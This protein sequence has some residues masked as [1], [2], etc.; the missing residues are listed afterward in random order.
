MFFV[1]L[2]TLFTLAACAGEQG[3]KGDQ[4][5]QGPIGV[6]GPTGPQGPEGPTGPQGPAGRDGVD[7]VSIASA[8]MNHLGELIIQLSNGNRINVGKVVGKDGVDGQDGQD[9]QD[10]AGVE[11][12]VSSSGMLQWKLV[13]SEAWIDLLVVATPSQQ[14][15]VVELE[16]VFT[17]LGKL[18]GTSDDKY[19][20]LSTDGVWELDQNVFLYNGAGVYMKNTANLIHE[21]SY[22]TANLE[23][24]KV[25]DVV[26]TNGK[27]TSLRLVN[28]ENLATMKS[29]AANI[30]FADPDISV[31]FG[32]TVDEL[33]A[34]LN[35]P[36]NSTH[37]V[38]S[39]T[40]VFTG[41]FNRA[42]SNYSLVV[43]SELGVPKTYTI[44]YL[45]TPDYKVLTK[46]DGSAL[47]IDPVAK[48]ISVQP[49][50]L[51]SS[52]LADLSVK[53]SVKT[54]NL[55]YS[56]NGS[57]QIV[58]SELVAKSANTL[59]TGD[60]VIVTAV[61][62]SFETYTVVLTTDDVS[63]KKVGVVKDVVADQITVAYGTQVSE[64]LSALVSVDGR[65]QTYQ[66]KYNN[67]NYN[68]ANDPATFINPPAQPW[69]LDVISGSG[70]K[71]TYNIVV[72]PSS[73]TD[74]Q[75]KADA[76]PFVT[77][78]ENTAGSRQI[79]VHYGLTLERMISHIEKADGS[80]LGSVS[81]VRPGVSSVL[82]SS[83][84]L[85]SGDQIVITAQNGTTSV[86]YLVMTNAKSNNTTLVLNR[87]YNEVPGTANAQNFV[88]SVAGSIVVPFSTDFAG[89]L[90]VQL[91][92][93]RQALTGSTQPS[94][95]TPLF[96]KVT[97]QVLDT[98]D[99]SWSNVTN[100]Y[101]NINT[102]AVAPAVEPQYR[103]LVQAQDGI[104]EAFYTITFEPKADDTTFAYDTYGP[105]QRVIVTS[106]GSSI[107][108]NQQID[109]ANDP[110]IAQDILDTVRIGHFQSKELQMKAKT[111]ET[112]PTSP[113]TITGYAE[114]NFTLNDYRLVIKSQDGFAN[115]VVV[116][117]PLLSVTTYGLVANQ[118]TIVSAANAGTITVKSTAP[119]TLGEVKNAVVAQNYSTIS[120]EQFNLST[121]DWSAT[122]VDS[123]VVEVT[124]GQPHF[125]MVITAQDRVTKRYVELVIDGL[126]SNNALQAKAGQTVFKLVGSD[127]IISDKTD[128]DTLLAAIDADAFS[129]TVTVHR[130]TEEVMTS[131]DK[132][133]NFFYVK[134][135]AQ[136]PAVAPMIYNI[137][138][139]S[140]NA[141]LAEGSYTVGKVTVTL[142]VDNTN[143]VA[144]FTLSGGT[145]AQKAAFNVTIDAV[146]SNLLTNASQTYAFETNEG[147]AKLGANLFTDDVIEVTA[148]DGS[149]QAYRVV[150]VR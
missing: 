25:T 53:V 67:V 92:N 149:V 117:N 85:F 134:V 2:V 94:V 116:A 135:Q 62:G 32:S 105:T 9:G 140:S 34:K 52:V 68:A 120:F 43:T 3:P 78:I 11:M 31:V 63:V 13:G 50:V 109:N 48:K 65:P 107:T 79:D 75:L 97:F 137:K 47:D 147:L 12:R 86:N 95:L 136:N 66:L 119:V 21:D 141:N 51:V 125:R 87:A 122:L 27:V 37:K 83:T 28:D 59:F 123:F 113:A 96:Q 39:G 128:L 14:V 138:V 130:N 98:T 114:L 16:G 91:V 74:I 1:L 35:F 64:F 127:L 80:P 19:Y 89:N 100:E 60:K 45:G 49:N 103:A 36:A 110:I 133:F 148:Q 115:Y 76:A 30:T 112:W 6:Q 144:T 70:M 101:V 33:I 82:P 99:G 29:G 61:D 88:K 118:T 7:G 44:S 69:T 23:S 22:F 84:Q 72:D 93:V 24:K 56:Y 26:L 121:G 142:S 58:N 73:A 46:K 4:G 108:V 104:A 126:Q 143:K 102:K 10:G 18:D 139:V 15:D 20:V 77:A 17:I 42:T 38:L 131:N 55:D 41:T 124:G 150:I 40:A 54:G 111:E 90:S 146:T 129:Q 5:I 57:V 132:L 8:E 106:S 71:A 145:D 81:I